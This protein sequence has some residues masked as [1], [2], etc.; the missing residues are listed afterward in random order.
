M[1]ERKNINI[2][3]VCLGD[4]HIKHS[5]TLSPTQ[6][7]QAENM[8][9]IEITTLKQFVDYINEHDEWQL[10]AKDIINSNRWQDIRGYNNGGVCADEEGCNLV[11]INYEGKAEICDACEWFGFD[12]D[13]EEL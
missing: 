4:K 10:D 11:V 12:E 9:K 6:H 8:K 2:F 5:V 13:E 3:A 1:V 7:G